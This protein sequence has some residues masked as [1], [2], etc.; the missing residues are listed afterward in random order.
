MM[1]GSLTFRDDADEYV[2]DLLQ[3][4]MAVDQGVKVV[5]T[6]PPTD[7]TVAHRVNEESSS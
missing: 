2:T 1:P 5:F 3:A 7:E 4:N 6:E